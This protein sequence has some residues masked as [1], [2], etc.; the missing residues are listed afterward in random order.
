MHDENLIEYSISSQQKPSNSL[1]IE[2]PNHNDKSN[3]PTPKSNVEPN[4]DKG[5]YS[6]RSGNS[7]VSEVVFIEPEVGSPAAE[8]LAGT[9]PHY[10]EMHVY[11]CLLIA[12][13]VT[14]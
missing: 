14:F 6:S 1:I 8:A 5:Q 11:I 3:N 2:I 13:Y 9:N 7:R 10:Y 12:L 4:A